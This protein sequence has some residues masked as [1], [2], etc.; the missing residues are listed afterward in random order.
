[1]DGDSAWTFTARVDDNQRRLSKVLLKEPLGP[2]V[3]IVTFISSNP[4]GVSDSTMTLL[5]R[6][7]APLVY[8]SC[9]KKGSA[10]ILHR[11]LVWPVRRVIPGASTEVVS[12]YPI[13][14]LRFS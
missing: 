14:R 3:G 4:D 10:A 7:L 6:E 5:R 2:C 12:Q 13:D 8:V 9:C 11:F 1:M